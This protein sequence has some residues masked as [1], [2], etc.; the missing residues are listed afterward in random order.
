MQLKRAALAI[1]LASFATAVHAASPPLVFE[2]VRDGF[3][4]R[5]AA[6]SAVL[7]A[8]E[9][10]LLLARPAA[11]GADEAVPPPPAV[12]RV[13]VVGADPHAALRGEAPLASVSHVRIGSDPAAWRSQVPHFTR[14]RA[15]GVR[16]GVD[17][18][19]YGNPARLET[20]YEIAPGADPG[21]L[22]L[23][24]EGADAL[25]I[26]E[27]GDLVVTAGGIELRE[28]RPV[29][30]QQGGGGR[31]A[32]EARFEVI[33]RDRVRFAVGAYD[34]SQ[35]LVIDPV[36]SYSTY[37]G[38]ALF[39]VGRRIVA[40][41]LGNSY[42]TGR[43]LSLD[44]PARAPL[45]QAGFG[46]GAY[47]AF[48]TKLDPQGALVWSTY[49]G[50]SG[51]DWGYDVDVDAQGYLYFVGRTDSPDLPV[52]RAL[53]PA[54]AGDTDS[55]LGK[56][57]PDG[58]GFVYLTYFG[59]SGHDRPRGVAA[60]D[61]GRLVATGFTSSPDHPLA[62]PIQATYGGGDFDAWV[63]ELSPFG[64]RLEFATFLGGAL[65]D[66]GVNVEVDAQDRPVVTGFTDSA[67]FPTA[68]A[69]QP[70]RAGVSD[71]FVAKIDLATPTPTLVFSTYLGGSGNGAPGDE[72]GADVAVD[73]AGNVYVAGRTRSA[74]FPVVSAAQS[75]L[76]GVEDA[77]VTKLAAGGT[78]LLYST[79][80]GGGAD[81]EA[82]AIAVNAAGLAFVTGRTASTDFPTAGAV[83]PVYGGGSEDAFVS[84]L[85]PNG[86]SIL[87]STFLGGNDA[88]DGFGIAIDAQSNVFVTG[89]TFSPNY[90][91]S[92]A[93]Q[94]AR[95][96]HFEAFVTKIL[97]APEIAV[98][99]AP[100]ASPGAGPRLTVQISNGSQAAKLVELKV[101]LE[102]PSLGLAPI[103]LSGISMP[104]IALGP[105]FSQTL[106]TDL[107][108]P[109]SLPF[110]G[111]IVGARLLDG[112]DAAVVSE[113]LC[114]AVPCH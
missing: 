25:R 10:T 2:A 42:V 78:P 15:A 58:T 64:D 91:T 107:A 57:R 55:F 74:D 111:S 8:G 90:P 9:A 69:V 21:A 94:P 5:G 53:Q 113:S 114:S 60:D 79:H 63:A 82:R 24:F 39:D 29:A 52:V 61:R 6:W 27:H 88:D 71:A 83:Q 100:P 109:A 97:E 36:L 47:D 41:A 3:A 103:S 34:R 70:A 80:L 51:E 81:D 76:R 30:Y 26:D 95:P 22:L 11:T 106:I 40:D 105:G 77:F 32:V 87:E 104:R 12:V 89:E 19:Y 14:V 7:S 68:N 13:H 93:A 66:V 17:V 23:A 86:A 50:G 44:F 65:A 35:T 49:F 18:V 72:L 28:S 54:L 99:L 108:L 98:R 84:I 92:H 102:A 20:D 110:P 16:P 85:A 112:N 56:L 75:T 46:G 48:V 43:T 33:G 73:A 45:Q 4:T 62:R 31:R 96:G 67:D 59:A 101:W 37:L 38:G 1:G